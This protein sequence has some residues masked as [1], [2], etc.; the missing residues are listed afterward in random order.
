M[1]YLIQKGASDLGRGGHACQFDHSSYNVVVSAPLQ[2]PP[3]EED[4]LWRLLASADE[5]GL[6]LELVNGAL[7]WEALPG[8]RHQELMTSTFLS[9]KKLDPSNSKCDCYRAI[10]VAVRFP[11]GTVKRPDVSIFCRRPVEEEGF[12]H[13]V[14]AAVIEITSPGYE[15]KDLITGPPIYL[16]NGVHDV[17]VLVR[18]SMQVHHWRNADRR[19]LSSPSEIELSCG[20]V[21]TV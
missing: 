17:I 12:V 14:P 9:I 3:I 4:Q 7:T 18:P 19:V 10:D 13:E 15:D 20:C 8:L 2:L 5:I 16:R 11:D 1:R 6:R 21:V